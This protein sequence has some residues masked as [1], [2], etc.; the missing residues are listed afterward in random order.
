MGSSIIIILQL[1]FHRQTTISIASHLMHSHRP[2]QRNP[3]TLNLGRLQSRY[4]SISNPLHFHYKYECS[5][6]FHYTAL[7]LFGVYK[8]PAFFCRWQLAVELWMLLAEVSQKLSQ[9]SSRVPKTA[10]KNKA[11]R[12][13]P[14]RGL[15]SW[16]GTRTSL[17]VFWLGYSLAQGPTTV[18]DLGIP[19]SILRYIRISYFCF[20]WAMNF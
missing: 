5:I 19:T 4:E 17:V 9:S 13:W 1:P 15:H 2:E 7:S 16:Y 3:A 20:W 8:P 12:K 11:N 6:I 10:I 18:L 14:P